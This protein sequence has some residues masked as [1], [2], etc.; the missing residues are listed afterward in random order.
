MLEEVG[1]VAGREGLAHHLHE[2]VYL[3]FYLLRQRDEYLV[4]VVDVF[5][6][7]VEEDVR[8]EVFGLFWA[9]QH[10]RE[11]IYGYY[12]EILGDGAFFQQSLDGVEEGDAPQ[13]FLCLLSVV[14]TEEAENHHY[15]L[16]G[17]E[18]FLQQ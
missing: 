15:F 6:Q 1:G 9:V 14:V 8:E 5:D 11:E 10:N 18:V 4:V 13:L 7:S 3:L 12:F 2:V 17:L 16:L